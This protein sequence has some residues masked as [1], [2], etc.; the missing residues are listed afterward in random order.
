MPVLAVQPVGEG[1]TAVFCGDTTW[2]WQQSLRAMDLESPFLQFWGQMVR[3]LAG[4]SSEVEA[5]AGVVVN[6]DKGYY[7][8]EEEIL[9]NPWSGRFISSGV[10]V[11]NWVCS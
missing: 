2:K 3:W 7:E 6:T 4:R 8:P 5:E 10:R 9:P 1:R 11:L